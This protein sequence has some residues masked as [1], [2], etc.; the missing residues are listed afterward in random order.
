MQKQTTC[1]IDIVIP[2]VD[3]SDP[4]WQKLKQ[5]YSGNITDDSIELNKE[6]RYRDW[7][8]LKYSFRSIEL[9]GQWVRHVFFVTCGQIPKWLNTQHPKLKLVNHEDYIPKQYLPTFSSHTIELNLHRIK[10]LSEYFVYFNDDF[11]LT[12]PTKPEDFFIN[13]LPCDTP[14]L[15]P[16]VPTIPGH[17]FVH[18]LLNDLS[19]VNGH[20]SLKATFGGHGNKWINPI[21]GTKICLRN[22]LFGRRFSHF[23]G[24]EN[25]HMP[26]PMLKS[27]FAKVWAM[28]PDILDATC[29]NRFRGL[30]DVNQYVM[31]YVNFCENKFIPRSSKYGRYFEI[32][33]N[34]DALYR[35]VVERQ[36]K[37]IAMNDTDCPID[38]EVEKKFLIDM[39][40]E[41]FPTRSSFELG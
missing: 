9:Y 18:Y 19:L 41:V 3:G 27:T 1:E 20:Y 10:D 8:T 22:L 13:G 7:D 25:F 4:E 40:E 36:Y 39:F 29:K 5:A 38:F 21:Y 12:A 2:W 24:F 15:M 17:V 33:N 28:E 37:Y 11:F 32:G 31:S 6:S 26:A 14:A 16:I 35:A 23:V 30:N 34:R